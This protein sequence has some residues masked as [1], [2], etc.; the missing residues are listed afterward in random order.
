LKRIDILKYITALYILLVVVKAWNM[1]KAEA[2]PWLRTGEGSARRA[3]MVCPE[4]ER[5]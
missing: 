3:A 4:R 2:G 1:L 5:P